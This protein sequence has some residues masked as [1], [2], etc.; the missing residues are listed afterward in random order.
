MFC[1]SHRKV[2]REA[3]LRGE[4]LRG[5][6]QAHLEV[7]TSCRRSFSE[8]QALLGL[9]E[10]GLRSLANQ[11]VPG[12]LV[13]KVRRRIVEVPKSRAWRPPFLAYV[14]AGLAI[15]AMVLL[16]GART[17]VPL[18]G[19]E[20]VVPEASSIARNEPNAAPEPSE[21]QR[22]L[23]AAKR[24]GSPHRVTSRVQPE[25]LVLAEEQL[26]LRRYAASLRAT[27][28]HGRRTVKSDATP[29]IIPLEIARIDVKQLSI[30][31][32]ESGDSN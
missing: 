21:P 16:F 17:R 19:E 18:A 24:N 26:G 27:A 3:A 4:R 31:P 13:L 32:L 1:E 20:N 30:E 23:V 5:E 8:E 10:G 6:A 2:L 9:L 25:V 22:E 12:S 29:E 7:C 14:T 28:S 15:G 11:E